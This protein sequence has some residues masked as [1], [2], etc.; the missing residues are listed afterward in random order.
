V[1]QPNETPLTCFYLSMRLLTCQQRPVTVKQR[2]HAVTFAE[3]VAFRRET[4][5]AKELK[6]K[7]HP[8]VC[9][10]A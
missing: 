5:I 8:N 4:E 1:P 2:L 7:P 6:R 10:H 9:M 3:E